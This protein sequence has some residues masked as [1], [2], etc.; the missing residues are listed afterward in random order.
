VTGSEKR[1]VGFLL[2]E[3]F[4]LLDVFGPAEIFGMLDRKFEVHMVGEALGAVSSAQGPQAVVSKRLIDCSDL[5]ILLVPG[6][7]GTRIVVDNEAVLSWLAS[8]A[9]KFEYITSVCTGSAVLAKAGLLDGRRATSNKMA[10]EWVESQGPNVNWV[11]KARWVEDGNLWTS[12]G[13]SAGIDMS[14]ALVKH[15]HGEKLADLAA[16]GAEYDW[17]RDAD[18]DPFSELYEYTRN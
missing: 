13:V 12:A 5:D 18:W 14:L 6:G 4:E 2:F 16:K 1:Q 9:D 11:K 8:S 17:H 3:G 7:D 15:L 10:F